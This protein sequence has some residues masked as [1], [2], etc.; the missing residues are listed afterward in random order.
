MTDTVFVDTSA[1]YAF[2]NSKDPDHEKVKSYLDKYKGQLLT[3]NFIFDEI[4]TLVMARVGH[5]EAVLTGKTL[6]NPKVFVMVKIRAPDEMN[7]WELFIN[8]PDKRYSFTDCTSFVIMKK[9]GI[10]KSLAVDSHFEQEGFER[11]I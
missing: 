8:R 10:K 6:L 7:A 11:V 4:L 9:L 1:L 5:K 2:I 3:T